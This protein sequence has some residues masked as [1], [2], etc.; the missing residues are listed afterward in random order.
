MAT[1]IGKIRK[2]TKK[3]TKNTSTQQEPIKEQIEDLAETK[4]QE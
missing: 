1:I 3:K 2:S 4:P